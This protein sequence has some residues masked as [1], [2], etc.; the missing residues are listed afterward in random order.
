LTWTRI[1]NHIFRGYE[2]W[3][4]VK[5]IGLQSYEIWCQKYIIKQNNKTYLFYQ[6]P[7]WR[8]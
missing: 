5:P 7:C 1:L 8:H 3:T 4:L 6:C 2:I